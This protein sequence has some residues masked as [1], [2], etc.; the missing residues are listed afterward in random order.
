[1]GVDPVLGSAAYLPARPAPT[2]RA[3]RRPRRPRRWSEPITV[4]AVTQGEAADG[5]RLLL[6][7]MDAS[8]CDSALYWNHRDV[9]GQVAEL[10][11]AGRGRDRCLEAVVRLDLD[12]E[13]GRAQYARRR[14]GRP[15][16]ASAAF[17]LNEPAD[18][19]GGWVHS[20][21]LDHVSLGDA[22]R[23]AD[24]GAVTPGWYL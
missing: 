23:Q 11:E 20:W 15:L 5:L 3:A 12:T 18:S 1:M 13:Q 9:I 16:A 14:A 21:R 7:G 22:G 19:I 17:Y 10:R 8:R 4:R 6:D 2:V 24:P